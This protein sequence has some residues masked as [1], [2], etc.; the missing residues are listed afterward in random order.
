MALPFV[1][2]VSS[3]RLCQIAIEA[4]GTFREF[5]DCIDRAN[6]EDRAT[7]L[8]TPTPTPTTTPTPT[9][10]P[11]ADHSV[12][13]DCEL[14]IVHWSDVGAS[15]YRVYVYYRWPDRNGFFDGSITASNGSYVQDTEY[16]LDGLPESD[17]PWIVKSHCYGRWVRSFGPN[18]V[19]KV[20]EN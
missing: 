17:H 19:R 5:R 13:I 10:M 12:F 6:W 4:G 7:P 11:T 2:P 14:G 15:R 16:S 18:K 1:S 9:P 3:Q 8:A 20:K